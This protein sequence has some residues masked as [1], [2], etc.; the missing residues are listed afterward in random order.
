MDAAGDDLRLSG[1][2]LCID[3]GDNT[4]SQ[5]SGITEDLDGN[6]RFVDALCVADTGN[7]T[8]P[9][10]DMGAYEQD[11][12]VEGLG[13]VLRVDP[14]AAGLDDGSS[15]A[16]AFGDL[17]TTLV[18]VPCSATQV[19]EIWVAEG[20]YRPTDS[21]DRTATF[22]LLS[23]MA[24]YGGFPPGGGDGTFN[25]RDPETYVTVLSGDLSGDD[26][27]NSDNSHHVVTGSG[28]IST[29]PPRLRTKQYH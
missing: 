6:P 21:T 13:S 29:P 7:G 25:A 14:S 28:T 23:G 17:Q 24:V 9:I 2:A 16:D 15:W 22:Q 4:V 26:P 27:V 20:T 8:A 3:A 18:L 12:I 1:R 5:L 11:G 10:V 19:D